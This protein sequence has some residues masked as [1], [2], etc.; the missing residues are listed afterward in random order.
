MRDQREVL[1]GD[2]KPL[3]FS[4]SIIFL[5]TSGKYDVTDECVQTGFEQSSVNRRG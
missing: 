5:M 1:D 4:G 2:D 3:D